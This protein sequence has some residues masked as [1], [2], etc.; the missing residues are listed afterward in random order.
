VERLSE[1]LAPHVQFSYTAWD[2]IVLNGYLE[3]LLR[4]ENLVHF[5]REVV[6]VPCVTPEVLLSRTPPYRAWVAR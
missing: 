6:G 1:L 3:R 4:P 5:F 2:R